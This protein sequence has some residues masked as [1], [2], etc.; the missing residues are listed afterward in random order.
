MLLNPEAPHTNKLFR[1]AK[2]FPRRNKAYTCIDV[3]LCAFVLRTLIKPTCIAEAF[4]TNVLIGNYA[5]I[6]KSIRFG[7]SYGVQPLT[8]IQNASLLATPS[9]RLRCAIGRVE[10]LR[11]IAHS[12][13]LSFLGQWT[14]PTR[15]P[16]GK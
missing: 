3:C 6:V 1:S 11:A 13:S 10:M 8:P 2:E 5:V 16:E 12:Q 9:M 4:W 14:I 15:R 7:N